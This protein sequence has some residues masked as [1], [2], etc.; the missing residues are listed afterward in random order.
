[1]P[2]PRSRNSRATNRAFT[3]PSRF[4]VTTHRLPMTGR[5]DGRGTTSKVSTSRKSSSLSLASFTATGLRTS[6]SASLSCSVV[7]A[8]ASS[9]SSSTA[10]SVV[11]LLSTTLLSTTCCT[12]C[13]LLL[14]PSLPSSPSRFSAPGASGPK[15]KFSRPGGGSL[16]RSGGTAAAPGTAC[17]GAGTRGG[18]AGSRRASAR[19]FSHARVW[20]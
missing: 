4:S 11:A 8:A 17:C 16:G 9:S 13:F 14:P 15:P 20:W 10:V 12:R 1:M 3:R 7:A 18:C 2:A 19:R 6:R 5:P